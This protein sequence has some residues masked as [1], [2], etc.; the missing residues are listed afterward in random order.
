MNTRP[1]PGSG[2]L[3]L[4]L[5]ALAAFVLMALCGVGLIVVGNSQLQRDPIAQEE[6]AA[7]EQRVEP[8][9]ALILPTGHDGSTPLPI[10]VWLHGYGATPDFVWSNWFQ[11][12]SDSRQVAV[13]GVSA[14]LPRIGEGYDWTED[15]VRDSARIDE[16]LQHYGEALT[17]APG[18]IVLFGFSQ[19]AAVA[20]EV[21]ARAPER[22]A[23]A[24][25]ISP[26]LV[27]EEPR[28][29]RSASLSGQGYVVTVGAEEDRSNLAVAREYATTARDRGARVV[30]LEVPGQAD[31]RFPDDWQEQLP[32]WLDFALQDRGGLPEVRPIRELIDQEITE[33]ADRFIREGYIPGDEIAVAVHDWMEVDS[34]R[35][36]ERVT[37][38]VGERLSRARVLEQEW[39]G[40]TDCDRLDRA[41][42]GLQRSGIVARQHFEDCG[43]CGI[44]AIGGEMVEAEE[45]GMVVRGYTF[46]HFQDTEGAAG[47]GLLY[48]SYG[49]SAEHASDTDG[50]AIGQEVASALRSEGLSVEWDGSFEHRIGIVGLDW[51]RRRFTRPTAR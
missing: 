36:R 8:S 46:F 45:L 44:G 27:G 20:A 21:A 17:P 5:L 22:Y 9:Q 47:G 50:V 35:Q 15:P 42:A 10:A 6:P 23:G 30:H 13:L 2:N 32:G 28:L 7:G 43:T 40:V 12:L 14:P 31:H 41:F 18:R 4:P 48:L 37:S 19:G 16:V 34:A 49:A 25:L 39:P 29:P 3:L 38:I 33:L 24:V 11:H 26:G 1:D 51:K